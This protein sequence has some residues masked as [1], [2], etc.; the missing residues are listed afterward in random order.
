MTYVICRDG[1]EKK[2][3]DRAYHP[4]EIAAQKLEV[5]EDYYFKVKFQFKN[6]TQK[7]SSNNLSRYCPVYWT[8]SMALMT[9]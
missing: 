2:S 1:S 4:S 5:D 9:K 6:L 3:M 7:K 8:Q